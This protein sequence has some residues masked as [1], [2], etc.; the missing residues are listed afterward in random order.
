M[1][2]LESSRGAATLDEPRGTTLSDL[3]LLVIGSALFWVTPWFGFQP[4]QV[5][6][7]QPRWDCNWAYTVSG[8]LLV[9]NFAH[10]CFDA[11]FEFLDEF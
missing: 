1:D 4:G 5:P 11:D 7:F 2:V 6:W 9:D 3:L 10:A 8:T